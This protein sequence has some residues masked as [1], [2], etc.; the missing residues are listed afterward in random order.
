MKKFSKI[1]KR[2]I[3]LFV[4][5]LLNINTYATQSSNDGSKFITKAEF[6]TLMEGFNNKMNEFESALNAKIDDSIAGYLAGL[7]GESVVDLEN[8]A[9]IYMNTMGVTEIEPIRELD[10]TVGYGYYYYSLCLASWMYVSPSINQTATMDAT[11]CKHTVGWVHDSYSVAQ[12]PNTAEN[13]MKRLFCLVDASG[14]INGLIKNIYAS[15]RSIYIIASMPGAG[16]NIINFSASYNN[17]QITMNDRTA[18][19]TCTAQ[20]NRAYRSNKWETESP[21]KSF[22]ET[23]NEGNYTY[24]GFMDN[25]LIS[26]LCKVTTTNIGCITRAHY[27]ERRMSTATNG[28][29]FYHCVENPYETPSAPSKPSSAANPIPYYSSAAVTGKKTAGSVAVNAGAPIYAGVPLCKAVNDGKVSFTI[30][31]TN[32]D[33]GEIFISDNP[34]GFSNTTDPEPDVLFSV[35]GKNEANRWTTN[36]ASS[37]SHTI[38]FKATKDKVYWIKYIPNENG[39]KY[40]IGDKITE[41]MGGV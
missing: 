37:G 8:Y 40:T 4:V 16:S 33:L 7:S 5:A 13:R 28:R 27:N 15:M 20:Y 31:L 1:G 21:A 41:T 26:Q 17:K 12:L 30:T 18:V 11:N 9:K 36:N 35:D 29:T 34:T 14:N 25:P 6:D 39:P 10:F 3:A 32:A 2:V 24:S 22:N 19:Y 23:Y 38:T